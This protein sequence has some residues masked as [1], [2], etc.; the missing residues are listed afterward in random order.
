MAMVSRISVKLNDQEM[1]MLK[2]IMSRH[3]FNRS[4]A[5]RYVVIE[6]AKIM[7][8]RPEKNAGRSKASRK[9]EGRR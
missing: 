6:T 7:K 9:P 3:G 1:A 8:L 4:E 2:R 5:L